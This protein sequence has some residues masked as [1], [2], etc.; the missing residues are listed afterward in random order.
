MWNRCFPFRTTAG[1]SD[2][3]LIDPLISELTLRIQSLN[4]ILIFLVQSF[5]SKTFLNPA[6]K[7]QISRCDQ[8][9]NV[10]QN[11]RDSD[12]TSLT[13][14]PG[15]KTGILRGKKSFL[16]RSLSIKAHQSSSCSSVVCYD[17]SAPK[18]GEKRVMAR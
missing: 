10:P 1:L 5:Q 18:I 13:V 15:G 2:V 11:I 7:T 14:L 6:S 16:E 12:V 17:A 8:T 9:G 4:R 3:P